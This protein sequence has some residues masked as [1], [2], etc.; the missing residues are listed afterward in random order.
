MHP[1][2]IMGGDIYRNPFDDK[3]SS[4]YITMIGNDFWYSSWSKN[5]HIP[6][7]INNIMI[8]IGY[9]VRNAW[10]YVC[11][12]DENT[13]HICNDILTKFRKGL[14]SSLYWRTSSDSAL[15]LCKDFSISFLMNIVS[16]ESL[17]VDLKT[18]YLHLRHYEYPVPNISSKP[19]E[20]FY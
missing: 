7:N 4:V 8:A 3:W 19:V 6:N 18:I 9:I 5:I 16:S 17:S 10:R 2:I 1:T 13:L 15:T 12:G 14:D 11:N 20:S